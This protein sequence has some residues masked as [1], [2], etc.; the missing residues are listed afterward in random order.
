MQKKSLKYL[1]KD[2]AKNCI[3]NALMIFSRDINVNF[4]DDRNIPVIDFFNKALGLTMS[5]DR[6]LS[7][8]KYKI[9][10]G[11]IFT[12]YFHNF[13]S[14]IFVSYFSYHKLIISIFNTFQQS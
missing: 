10:V 2:L 7:T 5:N 1:K 14:N 3:M 12:R 8:A 13:Q 4:A 9:T 11:A 6:I